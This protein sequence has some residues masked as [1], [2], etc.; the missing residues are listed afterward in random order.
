MPARASA[1]YAFGR[2]VS[3]TPAHVTPAVQ[4]GEVTRAPPLSAHCT[5]PHLWCCERLTFYS[6]LPQDLRFTFEH[7]AKADDVPYW[8]QGDDAFDS[9]EQMAMRQA[10]AIACAAKLP[11][12]TAP[13]RRQA[14]H[15]ERAVTP[16]RR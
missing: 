7:L 2:H 5:P 8:Q 9:E 10:R 4:D 12:A 11:P 16:R 3:P 15:S 13:R 6:S 14:A 1:D